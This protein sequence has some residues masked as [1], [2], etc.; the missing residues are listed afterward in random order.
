MLSEISEES[1]QQSLIWRLFE[2]VKEQLGHDPFVI[3]AR[4]GVSVRIDPVDSVSV[5]WDI[6]YSCFRPDALAIDIFAAPL[7]EFWHSLFPGCSPSLQY[8]YACWRELWHFWVYSRFAPLRDS[9]GK[10]W[11][12]AFK[13]L[14]SL[15]SRDEE[16]LAQY[17]AACATGVVEKSV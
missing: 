7:N 13:H 3:A 4:Q 16:R 17:F 1:T 6:S 11:Y 10:E 2:M 12:G 8:R 9:F 15:S 14:S 5:K